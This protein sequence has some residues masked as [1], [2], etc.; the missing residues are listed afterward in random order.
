MLYS[1]ICQCLP[2][3]VKGNSATQNR[4]LQRRRPRM[5]HPLQMVCTSGMARMVRL[6]LNREACMTRSI[7]KMMERPRMARDS[8]LPQGSSSV[9]IQHRT[10]S[11]HHGNSFICIYS[12]A[13]TSMQETCSHQPKLSPMVG[14]IQGAL[15]PFSHVTLCHIPA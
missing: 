3:P 10:I 8:V 12:V 6:I 4:R 2:E 5:L 15:F 13:D 7:M 1:W 11:H 9:S 14:Q